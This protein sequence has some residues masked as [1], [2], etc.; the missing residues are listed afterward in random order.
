MHEE[1][2]SP[3]VMNNYNSYSTLILLDNYRLS[4]PAATVRYVCAVGL[5]G[6][7]NRSRRKWGR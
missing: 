2:T 3:C 5:A 4:F 1:M 7:D 6:Y